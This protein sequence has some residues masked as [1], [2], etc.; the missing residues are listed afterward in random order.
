[1]KMS[2]L[3]DAAKI[4]VLIRVVICHMAKGISLSMDLSFNWQGEI[5]WRYVEFEI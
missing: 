2:G 5:Y 1:V 3:Q 4:E